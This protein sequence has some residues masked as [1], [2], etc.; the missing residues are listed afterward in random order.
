MT[1]SAKSATMQ[2][3]Q[4]DEVEAPFVPSAARAEAGSRRSIASSAT[5]DA[6]QGQYGLRGK[7]ERLVDFARRSANGPLQTTSGFE[8]PFRPE[9]LHLVPR[10]R[11]ERELRE[12]VQHVRLA[13]PAGEARASAC[14]RLARRP[15][16]AGARWLTSC[17]RIASYVNAK[18]SAVERARRRSSADRRAAG[19]RRRSRPATRR[20]ARRDRGRR[21]SPRS[22]RSRPRKKFGPNAHA[23]MS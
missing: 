16:R 9:L 22:S 8:V 6:D 23:M 15:R 21:A 4:E 17:S 18:S 13:A 1:P 5:L 12:E 19:T 2:V 3:G 20:R 14:R 10:P 7:T 11:E